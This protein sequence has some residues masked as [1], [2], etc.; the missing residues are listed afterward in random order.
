MTS[1]LPLDVTRSWQGA[2]NTAQD[3]IARIRGDVASSSSPTSRVTRVGKV[4]AELLDAELVQ[5]LREPLTK[6]LSLVDVRVMFLGER[7]AYA[8]GIPLVHIQGQ[9]RSRAHTLHPPGSLQAFC[10]GQRC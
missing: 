1:T 6:A 10:L 2:W 4:D 7:H 8:N 3:T 9:I 5:L